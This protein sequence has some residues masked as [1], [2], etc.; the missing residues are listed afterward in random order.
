[1]SVDIATGERSKYTASNEV[2]LSPQWRPGG[3]ISYAVRGLDNAGPADLVS[4]LAGGDDGSRSDTA[5]Q[6]A[7]RWH[8][9]GVQAEPA[10]G[11]H[12]IPTVSRDPEF[13]LLLSEPFPAFSPRSR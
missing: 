1:V 11:Q 7:G 10:A 4:G 3:K 6:L 12:L 13:E 8:A 2:T 9:G 5:S